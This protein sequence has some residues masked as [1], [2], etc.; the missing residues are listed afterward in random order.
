M[1][2]KL[3][4][5]PGGPEDEDGVPAFLA[6][7][8]S[9]PHSKSVSNALELLVDLGAMLPETN[10]LTDLG[11]CLSVISLE[12]RVAKMVIWSYILGCAR[13][14]STMAV[15]MSYKSPFVLPPPNR[16]KD[17]EKAQLDLS[18]GS[19]S[20]QFTVLNA[21]KKRDQLTKQ[22]DNGAYYDFCRRSFLS[23]STMQ[24]ISDLRKN[25]TRELNGLGFVG[26]ASLGQYHNR[27][28][29]PSAAAPLWQAAVA[30]GMFPN[31]ASRRQGDVNF[32]TMS[33]QKAK[34]HISSVNA[35][36]GQPLSQKCRVPS[37]QVEYV[38]FGEMVR[39]KNF[40][41]MSQTTH[42]ESPLPLLLL[43]GTSLNVRPAPTGEGEV[44][45]TSILS[46]DDWITFQ[47]PADV[48]A[49]VVI[50]RKRLNSAF[51]AFVANPS[52]GLSRLSDA[53]RGAVEALGPIFTSAH[54]ASD[55]R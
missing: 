6:K 12:P 22:Q 19:E 11:I 48:A 10:A 25:L 20:D 7:A 35:V 53:E 51:W 21:V 30:A 50:L 29:K 9:P 27:H 26:P 8:M 15:A 1:A 23:T 43:C 45:D 41:T 39:G 47:C 31:L 42:L 3:D 38:C 44:S 14:I 36:K 33:N 55:V 24:M 52:K 28:E 54:G 34:I 17:A 16:R 13:T 5:A 2:K 18:R 46:V 32:S 4:L 40:F 49:G 37:H